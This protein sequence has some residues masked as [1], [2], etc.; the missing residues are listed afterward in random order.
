MTCELVALLITYA[1]ATIGI[2]LLLDKL[3]V[4]RRV[5]PE[6]RKNKDDIDYSRFIWI[7]ILDNQRKKSYNDMNVLYI[8]NV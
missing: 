1:I 2:A 6:I 8:P 3:I 5:M 4:T 7:Y